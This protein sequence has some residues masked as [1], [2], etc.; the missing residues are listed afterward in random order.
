M[1]T[2]SQFISGP[3]RRIM[4]PISFYPEPAII[5]FSK[6]MEV[7]CLSPLLTEKRCMGLMYMQHCIGLFPAVVIGYKVKIQKTFLAEL[8]YP[9]STRRF[10]SNMTFVIRILTWLQS[11][12]AI[13]M[14]TEVAIYTLVPTVEQTVPTISRK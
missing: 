11:A 4:G 10:I 5:W 3:A 14:M 12:A 7:Q 1:P 9:I 6:A 8:Q 2:A 13:L